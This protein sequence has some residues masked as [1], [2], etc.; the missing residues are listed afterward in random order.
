MERLWICC[1]LSSYLFISVSCL[2][3]AA[4]PPPALTVSAAPN[5]NQI[6][7]RPGG[8]GCFSGSWRKNWIKKGGRFHGF[9]AFSGLKKIRYWRRLCFLRWEVDWQRP[10]SRVSLLQSAGVGWTHAGKK[11]F[12]EV[13]LFYW[14]ST[15]NIRGFNL[16][17]SKCSINVLSFALNVEV[18]A[19]IDECSGSFI[20]SFTTQGIL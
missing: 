15:I 18:Y 12:S 14:P 2:G 6:S 16:Q 10:S 9:E 5:W 3:A 1:V 13:E 4:P 11:T 17:I 8:A 20:W 7:G 19:M